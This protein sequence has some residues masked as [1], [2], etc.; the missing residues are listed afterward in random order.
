MTAAAS[1]V[2]YVTSQPQRRV[3]ELPLLPITI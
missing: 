3:G 2:Q 1:G